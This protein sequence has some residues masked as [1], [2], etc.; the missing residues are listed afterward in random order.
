MRRQLWVETVVDV[1]ERQCD[2]HITLRIPSESTNGDEIKVSGFIVS[3][4]QEITESIIFVQSNFGRAPIIWIDFSG[5]PSSIWNGKLFHIKVKDEL[6]TAIIEIFHFIDEQVSER[7]RDVDSQLRDWIDVNIC[8]PADYVFNEKLVQL[9][10]CL[11]L[12]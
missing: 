2:K 3:S 12:T 5:T 6:E 10:T 4:D 11:H 7:V 1:I 8:R 9:V